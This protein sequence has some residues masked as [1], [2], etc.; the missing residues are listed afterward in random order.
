MIKKRL[1]KKVKENK[2]S[3][4]KMN[5]KVEMK[6]KN[7]N[8]KMKKNKIM[9]III[10]DRKNIMKMKILFDPTYEIIIKFVFNIF[11]ILYKIIVLLMLVI[12]CFYLLY[13]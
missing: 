11:K 4:K 6:K 9:K 7:N 13:I 5:N 8:S 12:I 2:N 3:S 10:Q 1:N